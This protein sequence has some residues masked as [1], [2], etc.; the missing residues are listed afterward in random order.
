VAAGKGKSNL[1]FWEWK[2]KEER[3]GKA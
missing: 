1:G 3:E 2:G